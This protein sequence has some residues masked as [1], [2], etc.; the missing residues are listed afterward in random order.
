[1]NFGREIRPSPACTGP[2]PRARL[3]AV[4][5]KS[6]IAAPCSQAR[7]NYLGVEDLSQ[8]HLLWCTLLLLVCACAAL[9]FF[10]QSKAA[11]G[12]PIPLALFEVVLALVPPLAAEMKLSAAILSQDH[13][14]VT[15]AT[16][17]KR[18]SWIKNWYQRW[19][20]YCKNASYINKRFGPRTKC[21]GWGTVRST[22]KHENAKRI[23]VAK[24]S[25]K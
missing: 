22:G 12:I 13:L 8:G 24:M 17:V 16:T 21:M 5:V 18:V 19:W 7:I 11:L 1:M 25:N 9:T 15:Q 2:W 10:L 23:G 4:L 3:G 20:F 14:S 6:V